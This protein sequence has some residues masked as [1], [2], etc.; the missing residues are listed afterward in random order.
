MNP[1]LNYVEVGSSRLALL[2]CD[3]VKLQCCLE[4]M[5]YVHIYLFAACRFCFNLCVDCESSRLIG[6]Q[7][8]SL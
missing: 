3:I 1:L 2:C 5:S 4:F 6:G 8:L 7:L